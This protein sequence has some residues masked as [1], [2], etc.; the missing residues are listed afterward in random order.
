MYINIG[1]LNDQELTD[2]YSQYIMSPATDQTSVIFGS[3]FFAS[4]TSHHFQQ[5]LGNQFTSP[6]HIHANENNK[7]MH[8]IFKSGI[9]PQI[10]GGSGIETVKH[11]DQV[12]APWTSRPS[13]PGPPP[14]PE[15]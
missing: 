10:F 7:F 4:F 1:V 14:L 11:L 12:E 3:P 13:A 5:P 15:L 2:G 8:P 9:N 6:V